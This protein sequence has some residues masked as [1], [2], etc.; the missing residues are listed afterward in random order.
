MQAKAQL[1]ESRLA[2]Q[3]EHPATDQAN[4]FLPYFTLPRL[5]HLCCLCI[6]TPN[7]ISFFLV[8]QTF[9]TFWLCWHPFAWPP[10]SPARNAFFHSPSQDQPPF[11]NQWTTLLLSLLWK[12]F[13]RNDSYWK[14]PNDKTK[15]MKRKG[16][17]QLLSILN[18]PVSTKEN[19]LAE[20]P[21]FCQGFK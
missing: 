20:E 18:P 7:T 21:Q 2:K 11:W 19:L 10:N 3:Q 12:F 17:Q 13:L 1:P 9:P 5:S 16:D 4:H 8:L 15:Q 6:I 14:Q